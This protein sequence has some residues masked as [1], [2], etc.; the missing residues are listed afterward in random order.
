[1]G[2]GTWQVGSCGLQSAFCEWPVTGGSTKG[3][4]PRGRFQ[5]F[6]SALDASLL[7]TTTGRDQCAPFS[8]PT[9]SF[10]PLGGSHCSSSQRVCNDTEL[11]YRRPEEGRPSDLIARW[12]IRISS[13]ATWEQQLRSRIQLFRK[14]TSL[15]HCIGTRLSS[16]LQKIQ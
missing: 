4:P 8:T 12:T 16:T 2:L 3:Q 10:P 5:F 9:P 14:S 13:Q 11:F 6:Q 15:P 1:M 7:H